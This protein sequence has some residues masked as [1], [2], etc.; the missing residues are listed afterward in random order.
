MCGKRAC[1]PVAAGFGGDD[2]EEHEELAVDAR[3]A[4]DAAHPAIEAEIDEGRERPDLLRLDEAAE[5]AG[6][7]S[8]RD[9]EGQREVL[10]S[11]G[12]PV[13]RERLPPSMAQRGPTSR[14]RRM[15]VSNEMSAARKLGTE[16]RIQT[17]RVRGTR[18]NASRPRVCSGRRFSAK[19]RRRKVAARASTLATDATTPSLTSR[20]I[21]M[22]LSVTSTVYD[23]QRGQTG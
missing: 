9:V 21:R 4:E 17:P 11:G 3:A 14:P 6:E 16:V 2:E 10:A 13:R 19:N 8:D 18:K 12:P 1:D 22:S 7:K 15:M 20:V 5:D 23:L